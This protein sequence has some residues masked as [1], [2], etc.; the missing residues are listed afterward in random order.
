MGN[1]YGIRFV[2]FPAA[3]GNPYDPSGTTL[4]T[5][6]NNALTNG[7]TVAATT[8]S[9]PAGNHIIYA[10]LSPAPADPACRPS[11]NV[12]ITVSPAATAGIN[13][14]ETSGIP[15]DG[16]LCTGGSA[17]LTA[18]GGASYIWSP[19]GATT[20]SIPVNVAGVYTVTVVN[21]M[22][23]SGS[24]SVNITTIAPPVAL[25]ITGGGTRCSNGSALPIA[26]SGTGQAGVR[27][28][29]LRN[30]VA[31]DSITLSAPGAVNFP[32]QTLAGTYT[33]NATHLTTGCT[34]LM[35]G[36]A[37]I[38]VSPLPAA[39]AVTGGGSRCITGNALPVGLSG[40]GEAGVTY[41]LFL[42]GVKVDSI[43]LS[44]AGPVN[45]QPQSAAGTYTADAYN[46]TGC[47][48]NMTGSAVINITAGPTPLTVTGGGSRCSD[49]NGLPIG[50]SGNGEAGVRYRL[51]LNG[52]AVDSVLLSVPGIVNFT[53][54][55]TAG[56]YTVNATNIAAAC[57]GSM[58]GS[59]TITLANCGASIT[60]P[61][62]CLNNATTLENG[63]FGETITVTAPAGQV[64]TVVSAP[65]L[66]AS[67]SPN[68]PSNPVPI[69]P[70]TVLTASGTTYTLT[71]RHVDAQGYTV[72]VTNGRGT[73]LT[74]SNTCAYPNPSITGLDG[75][76]CLFSPAVTLAGTPGDANIV[77]QG[78]TINGN[79]A[80]VFNPATL[81]IGDHTVVYTVNGGVP[82]ASGANDP[83]CI[84]SVS[85]V[86][87]IVATSPVVTC[88]D[89]IQISLDEDCLVTV[90]PDDVLEGDRACYDD[91]QVIIT[92]LSGSVPYGTTVTGALIGQTLKVTIRHRVSGN[93]CWGRLT[94]EDKLP[95]VLTC[96]P[97]WVPCAAQD[98]DPSDDVNSDSGL[99]PRYLTDDADLLPVGVDNIRGL[100][101]VAG[102]LNRREREGRKNTC[103]S[104][105]K[106]IM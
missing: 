37:V 49:D 57:T 76:L 14:V 56:T 97:V 50:L 3:T 1:T 98:F 28:R 11:A 39:L 58:I 41:R 96:E 73:T 106:T 35:V 77:S 16:I 91:Y 82:K 99:D 27:Y 5:V 36:T 51:L 8:A 21:D 26:L 18:T 60:D 70:G 4:A 40:T 71:G 88:N 81:G 44:A 47:R 66:Y 55:T 46:T 64:W 100:G 85:K 31:V 89:N 59:V 101:I 53:P 42:N 22:G 48:A 63:Q 7:G 80:T 78:F 33:A 13:V 38:T 29:L 30:G 65:G 24:A 90:F 103:L 84:Q 6:S 61:C 52:I 68:P 32:A 54:Q 20:A 72:T 9:A 43:I 92:N 104:L 25:N 75:P 19:G 93:T 62:T 95:P 23:C 83:G 12:A 74:I 94:V 102:S 45:F 79:A 87:R 69:T 2:A 17:T 67:T 86:V 15:N 105:C 34:S 10:I